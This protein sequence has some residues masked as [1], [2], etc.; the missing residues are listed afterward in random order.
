[1]DSIWPAPVRKS[2]SPPADV[3][4]RAG[5][6]GLLL[7]FALG[8]VHQL[9]WARERDADISEIGKRDVAPRSIISPAKELAI[10][11]QM[12]SRIDRQFE[13]IQDPLVNAYIGG[14]AQQITSNSDLE[15]PLTVKVIDSPVVGAFT[16][17][18]GFLYATSGLVLFLDG[19]GELAAAFAHEIAHLA[20]RHWASMMT[21]SI[22]LQYAM[23]P[24]VFS[25]NPA[26]DS[27][28]PQ[29]VAT[30][31]P[32]TGELDF[33]LQ[34]MPLAFLKFAREGEA[35]ADYLGVQYLYKA[36]YDPACYVAFL[37]KIGK[38]EQPDQQKG[39]DLF[40]VR[41]PTSKRIARSEKEIKTIPRHHGRSLVTTSQLEDMKARLRTLVT[42]LRSGDQRRR[43]GSPTF[44]PRF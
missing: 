13:F 1:M 44:A 29:I 39:R 3:R 32:P 38:V 8:S 20:A 33:P 37:A 36:A 24:P 40:A 18:G 12:A 22:L 2:P 34:G 25:P 10:G 15:I 35:E 11:K 5:F 27:P 14:I 4:R 43:P 21:K 31:P 28:T 6:A 7:I 30:Y 42:G 19:E 9:A 41:P 16:L 26:P 23:V 17:P